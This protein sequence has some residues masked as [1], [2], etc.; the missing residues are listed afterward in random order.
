MSKKII[1][2]HIQYTDGTYAIEEV[3]MNIRIIRVVHAT[4]QLINKYRNLIQL[5]K[6]TQRKE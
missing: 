2:K 6:T 3:R 4:F 1:I 5:N